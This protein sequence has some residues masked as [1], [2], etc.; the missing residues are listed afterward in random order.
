[1]IL[2]PCRDPEHKAHCRVGGKSKDTGFHLR[3]IGS[4]ALLGSMAT[5]VNNNDCALEN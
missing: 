2:F 5:A 4:K 1:M 3:G